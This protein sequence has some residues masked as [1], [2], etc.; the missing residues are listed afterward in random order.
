MLDNP[1]LSTDRAL[2]LALV[3]LNRSRLHPALPTADW[4]S[5]V[6]R[7][8][9]L[10]VREG[11]FLEQLRREVED[12]ATEAPS[13][14]DAF[15]KWFSDLERTGPGQHDPLFPWL[16][17]RAT[18]DQVKWFLTQEVAGE[19]GFED[20]T[21]ATQM[22]FPSGPKLEMA[23]NYWDEMGRGNERG[24]HGL[25][26]QAVAD[27]LQLRPTPESTV[28]EA[29]MLANL[30][31]GLA[32]NRRYA[33]HSIGALGVIELTAPGRAACVD[34]AMKRLGVPAAVRRYFSLH[35][36]LDV[37]HSQTWNAEVISPLIERRP[38]IARA[39][40]E[41]ALMRLTCGAAC[42]DRYRAELCVRRGDYIAET[43][44]GERAV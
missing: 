1:L 19:A 13:E 25:M 39:I 43:A 27:N 37:R 44:V 20:L 10:A 34:A 4:R 6:R 38:D 14:P 15:I 26:L 8:S 33:F 22:R 36:V 21:A 32:L 18:L 3:E 24:M 17:E 12:W 11:E 42:F 35:A 16:A 40:A 9:D 28:P 41:G 30:M 31:A 2:Q 5:D 7:L 29:L 23:R